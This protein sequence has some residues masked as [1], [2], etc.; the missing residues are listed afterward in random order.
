MDMSFPDQ[1]NLQPS[2][3][4]VA[5]W[6][7]IDQRRSTVKKLRQE[8]C[9]LEGGLTLFEK[10]LV[11]EKKYMISPVSNSQSYKIIKSQ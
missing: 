8:A 5:V 4:E 6:Q 10:I 9:K 11:L 7:I 2:T 3:V 1:S